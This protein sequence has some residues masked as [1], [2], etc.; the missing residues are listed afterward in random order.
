MIVWLCGREFHCVCFDMTLCKTWQF[1]SI[2]LLLYSRIKY[3]VI[4]LQ[5]TN[6]GY[7]RFNYQLTIIYV[8]IYMPIKTYNNTECSFNFH[9]LCNI[10]TSSRLICLSL[11]WTSAK[12]SPAL[13][14]WGWSCNCVLCSFSHNCVDSLPSGSLQALDS[15]VRRI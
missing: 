13:S 8:L 1:S 6:H 3:I 15:T 4:M 7:F 14:S 10:H 12:S 9:C 5:L 11:S 2:I